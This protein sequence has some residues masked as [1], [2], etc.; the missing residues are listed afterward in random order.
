MIQ[1][2]NESLQA[3]HL[4]C[5]SVWIAGCQVHVLLL[6]PAFSCALCSAFPLSVFLSQLERWEFVK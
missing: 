2:M 6:H 1:Y 3:R 4:Q 5:F